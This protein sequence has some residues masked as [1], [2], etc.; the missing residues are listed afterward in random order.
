MLIVDL[1]L[2]A[3]F[4]SLQSSR[5]IPSSAFPFP[6]M[7]RVQK[8][9][10]KSLGSVQEELWEAGSRSGSVIHHNRQEFGPHHSGILTKVLLPDAEPDS[11]VDSF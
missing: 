2:F 9:F 1:V 7:D 3:Y 6:L 10:L 8:D 5:V 4:L 11:E